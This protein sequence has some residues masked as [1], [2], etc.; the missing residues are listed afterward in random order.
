MRIIITSTA[1][2]SYNETGVVVRDLRGEG[3]EVRLDRSG[4]IVLVPEK[5]WKV[6]K[7]Q[8]A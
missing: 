1:H 3:L 5:Q 4:K 7:V 6:L 8:E 2:S